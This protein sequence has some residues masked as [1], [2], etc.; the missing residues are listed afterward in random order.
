VL[1]GAVAPQPL[2]AVAGWHSEIGQAH[3]RIE[4]AEFPQRHPMD[5]RP[6]PSDRLSFEETLSVPVPKALNHEKFNVSR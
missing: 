6:Q 3:R 4:Y 5:F 2:Q 1:P